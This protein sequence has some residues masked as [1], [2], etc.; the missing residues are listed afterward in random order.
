MEAIF[1]R[2]RKEKVITLLLGQTAAHKQLNMI[3]IA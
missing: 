3:W 1:L 2:S